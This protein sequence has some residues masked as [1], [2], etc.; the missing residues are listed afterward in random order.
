[1]V[2]QSE[3]GLAVAKGSQA[4]VNLVLSFKEHVRAA[5]IN[6]HNSTPRSKQ[7]TDF[8][9]GRAPADLSRSFALSPPPQDPLPTNEKHLPPVL[10][11]LRSHAPSIRGVPGNCPS[12]LLLWATLSG[13]RFENHWTR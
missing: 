4:S 11:Q 6:C 7:E 9:L 13:A 12:S 1:M 5:L 2:F 10:A 8:S 3:R